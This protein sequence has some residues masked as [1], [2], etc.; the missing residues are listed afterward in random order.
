M[1]WE[2]TFVPGFAVALAACGGGVHMALP[3]DLGD[4]MEHFETEGRGDTV[5]EEDGFTFAGYTV[6]HV[7]RGESSAKG[8]E[9]IDGFTPAK[10]RG[11]RYDFT[12]AGKPLVGKCAELAPKKAGEFSSHGED[13]AIGCTCQA[14]TQSRGHLFLEDLAGAYGG[15]VV[16]GN[17]EVNAAS[18]KDLSNGKK[19]GAPAGYRLDDENGAVGAVEV[20]PGEAGV[21]L[22]SD[23]KKADRDALACLYAGLMLYVPP[24]AAKD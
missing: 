2:H 14:G 22:R 19:L 3:Q 8:F 15:P 16:V 6:A 5:S 11:Y 9:V 20:I 4:T 24:A 12:G 18:I 17:V 10:D 13:V 21:W 1:R 23:L 7:T